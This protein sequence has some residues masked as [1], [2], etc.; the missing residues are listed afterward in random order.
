MTGIRLESDFAGLGIPQQLFKDLSRID[1]QPLMDE[2]GDYLLSETLLN[3]QNTQTPEGQTWKKSR[4]AEDEGGKTL[5]DYG[6]L[7][8]SYT[9]NASSDSVEVGSALVYAAIHHNGGTI[10]AKTSKGLKFKIGDSWITKQSIEMP[11]RPAL[12]LTDAYQ[13]EIGQMA[14]A[15]HLR[16]FN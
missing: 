16:V 12:G 2:V 8:D 4:R 11:A 9:Y 6:H 14:I 13:T 10:E 1:T 5:T 15:F 7:R 3:F